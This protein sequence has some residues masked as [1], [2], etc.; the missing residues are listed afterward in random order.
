MFKKI[1]KTIK[2]VKILKEMH[3]NLHTDISSP[4][5]NKEEINNE[6]Y[7][8]RKGTLALSMSGVAI[9]GMTVVDF[10]DIGHVPCII[11]D[12]R[13]NM[14]SESTRKFII[15]HE[16]GH[17]HL[18]KDILLQ[19]VVGRNLDL[20]CEADRFAANVVGNDIAIKALEEI[21]EMVDITSFGKEKFGMDEI[22]K[23]IKYLKSL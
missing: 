9:A 11:Y 8:I 23:R 5:F 3:E 17:F 20:E 13:F 10:T 2:G 4:V 18:Q 1:R 16:L 15:Y 12:D 19:G 7:I 6:G 21:K 22:D 14:M